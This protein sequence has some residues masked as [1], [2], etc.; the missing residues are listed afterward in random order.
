[1]TPTE[2]TGLIAAIATGLAVIGTGLGA[3]LRWA[4]GGLIRAIQENTAATAELK[5]EVRES[6][7]EMRMAFGIRPPPD[8]DDGETPDLTPVRGVPAGVGGYLM[9]RR[10]KGNGG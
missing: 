10:G 5:L 1:M 7:V 4:I 9:V 6:R 3:L 8:S 2:L